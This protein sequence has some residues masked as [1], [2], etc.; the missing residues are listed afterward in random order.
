[1]IKNKTY[2]IGHVCKVLNVKEHQLRYL[3]RAINYDIER[4]EYQKRMYTDADIYNLREYLKLKQTEGYSFSIIKKMIVNSKEATEE[5]QEEQDNTRSCRNSVVDTD[6]SLIVKDNNLDGI[7]VVQD[8]IWQIKSI[9]ESVNT[10]ND[11]I[12]KIDQIEDMNIKLD[13]L[14]DDNKNNILQI[15]QYG[16]QRDIDLTNKLIDILA[17][18]REELEKTNNKGFFN[19]ISRLFG[20]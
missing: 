12:R 4:D 20:A 16:N 5:K 14:M 6:L 15:K 18:R 2:P 3:E 19:K 8:L 17:K 7:A 10:M 11:K 9:Q 13:K 1:M